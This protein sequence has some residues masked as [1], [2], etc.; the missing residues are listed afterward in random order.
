MME[1]S[2]LAC[3]GGGCTPPPF[4]LFTLIYKVAVYAPAQR[5]DNLYPICTLWSPQQIG[6]INLSKKGFKLVCNVN[7]VYGNLKSENS[8]DYAQ[9]QQRNCPFM[10]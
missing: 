6:F 3:E 10:N 5:A 1:K 7:I 4:T 2:A 9:K 8:Q